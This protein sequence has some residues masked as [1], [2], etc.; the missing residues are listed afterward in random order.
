MLARRGSAA[1]L[2]KIRSSE[3][4]LIVPGFPRHAQNLGASRRKAGRRLWRATSS[5]R[6]GKR[7]VH[8]IS[9]RVVFRKVRDREA[10]A[11]PR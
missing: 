11:L 10:R 9:L 7:P 5:R 6:L 1:V 3:D 8:H 4:E 2:I